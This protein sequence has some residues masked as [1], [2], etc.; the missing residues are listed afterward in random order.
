MKRLLAFVFT[1]L[2]TVSALA[3]PTIGYTQGSKV[4][5]FVLTT[6]DGQEIS[7]YAELEE[8]ELVVLHFFSTVCEACVE[9]LPLLQSIWEQYSDQVSFIVVDIM[10]DQD[11]KLGRFLQRRGVTYPVGVDRMNL[12]V[13]YSVF[14]VPV[15]MIIDKD[16]V[17]QTV[18]EGAMSEIADFEAL[19]A[20]YLLPDEAAEE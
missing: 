5:D 15:T 17:L 11:A 16:G 3:E 10:D 6:W 13:Q 12:S 1:L 8:K 20:P 4:K 2:L 9:E 19:V 7:L 18:K 14:G